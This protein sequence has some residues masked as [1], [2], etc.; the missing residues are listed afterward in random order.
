[1]D[2]EIG[3][4]RVNLSA[5]ALYTR[6]AGF[7]TPD[8]T[9]LARNL[10]RLERKRTI[11]SWDC[12][13]QTGQPL[14]R[15]AKVRSL[16]DYTI[17]KHIR[18]HPAFG[19][20]AA[21]PSQLWFAAAGLGE[22]EFGLAIRDHFPSMTVGI[23]WSRYADP[24]RNGY[25]FDLCAQADYIVALA[26]PYGLRP[27]DYMLIMIPADVSLTTVVTGRCTDGTENDGTTLFGQRF[28]RATGTSPAD[29]R[30]RD[31]KA[32][33]DREEKEAQEMEGRIEKAREKG[34]LILPFDWEYFPSPDEKGK[35]GQ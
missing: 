3:D 26:R 6:N 20:G 28:D 10:R 19:G 25:S 18:W 29:Q 21:D 33:L 8:F 1:M 4:L 13:A 32:Q 2:I 24:F 22:N 11:Y 31:L 34:P 7:F 30:Y 17:V 16:T 9:D 27:E 35:E 12:T 14:T 15:P 23:D 5:E